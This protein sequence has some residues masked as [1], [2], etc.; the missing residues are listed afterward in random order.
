MVYLVRV[1]RAG[2]IFEM[3]P[4]CNPQAIRWH[5]DG[6]TTRR[7]DESDY[8]QE[9]LDQ[10]PA[11]RNVFG[12]GRVLGFLSTRSTFIPPFNFFKNAWRVNYK[13]EMR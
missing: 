12:T 8:N 11:K 1:F 9:L 5:T 3:K 4:L 2:W 13:M 6:C 10:A 7:R